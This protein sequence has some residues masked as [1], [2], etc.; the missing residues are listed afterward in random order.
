MLCNTLACRAACCV[1]LIRRAKRTTVR[2]GQGRR[3]RDRRHA[4]GLYDERFCSDPVLP[5]YALC[6]HTHTHVHARTRHVPSCMCD[7]WD[8]GV[9]VSHQPQPTPNPAYPPTSPSICDVCVLD[10]VVLPCPCGGASLS[11]TVPSVT[12]SYEHVETTLMLRRF[13]VRGGACCSSKDR[14][15]VHPSFCLDI[16]ISKT[17]CTIRCLI[18]DGGAGR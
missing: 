11:S 18:C 1:C 5:P 15:H 14:A 4:L 13:G 3:G 2:V 12:D 8:G 17:R 10:S 9:S 7:P 6:T 16:P